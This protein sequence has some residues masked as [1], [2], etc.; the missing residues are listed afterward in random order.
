MATL[1]VIFNHSILL[2]FP[3][4]LNRFEKYVTRLI[5]LMRISSI[6][7]IRMIIY[8]Y[9]KIKSSQPITKIG[10]LFIC[11]AANYPMSIVLSKT[12]TIVREKVYNPTPKLN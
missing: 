8:Q 3:K 1:L 9:L 12:M 5:K 7:I 11:L 4:D 2:R 6:Y 10:R